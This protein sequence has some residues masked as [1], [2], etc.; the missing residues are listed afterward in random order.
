MTETCIPDWTL[1]DRL[2]KAREVAGLEQAELAQRIGISRHTVGNYELGRGVRGPKLI[3]LRAWS[4]ETGVPL[5]WLVGEHGAR[6][7][8]DITQGS[9]RDN[10]EYS[11]AA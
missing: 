1:A 9:R 5:A 8:S 3:V 11:R 4:Q 6:R 7:A 10:R 2:R